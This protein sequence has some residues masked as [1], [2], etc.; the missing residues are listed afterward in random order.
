MG[1]EITTFG[2]I[3]IDE[4][5]WPLSPT[6]LKDIDIDN[7]CVCVCVFISFHLRGF[8]SLKKQPM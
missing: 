5:T 6:F 2:D 1:K 7:V 3:E 4:Q 8:S